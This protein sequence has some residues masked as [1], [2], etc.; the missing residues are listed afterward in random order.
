MD[1]EFSR[2]LK[3]AADLLYEKAMLPPVQFDPETAV[4]LARLLN[5]AATELFT[6]ELLRKEV[7]SLK[8]TLRGKDL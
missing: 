6:V 1:H 8:R 7:A 5:R 3:V 2:N 4:L